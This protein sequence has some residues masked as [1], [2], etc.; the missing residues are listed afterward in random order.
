M[1][2]IFSL[3]FRN[4]WIAEAKTDILVPPGAPTKTCQSLTS[5]DDGLAS[6]CSVLALDITAPVSLLNACLCLLLKT[7]IVYKSIRK[8]S[9]AERFVSSISRAVKRSGADGT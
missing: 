8:S 5:C 3:D 2:T 6:M 4:I 9:S 7:L 1:T